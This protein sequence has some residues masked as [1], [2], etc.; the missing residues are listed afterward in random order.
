MAVEKTLKMAFEMY[1]GN[2]LNLS[3]KNPKNG[4]TLTNVEAF[5]KICTDNEA[6]IRNDATVLRLDNA[7]IWQTEKIEL[8][9]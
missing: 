2:I 6:L 1:D 9:A 5:A 3:L 8:D 4:L 7:Y